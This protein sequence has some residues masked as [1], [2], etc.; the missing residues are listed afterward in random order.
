M[1]DEE[2]IKILKHRYASGEIS[3]K[4]YEEMKEPPVENSSKEEN[5]HI[6]KKS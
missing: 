6:V 5:K 2:Y 4:E 1:A 3:K